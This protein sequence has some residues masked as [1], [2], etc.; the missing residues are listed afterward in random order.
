MRVEAVAGLLSDHYD[1]RSK[2]VRL[3]EGVLRE[4]SA[5]AVAVAAHECGHAIQH[6]QAYAPL[7]WRSA[8]VGPVNLLNTLAMPMFIA[9]A[10][11]QLFSLALV[12]VVLFGATTLFHLVTLPVEFDA[13]KRA[14][15]ILDG[16]GIATPEEMV[17]VRKVLNA[18][19]FTY[20]AATLVSAAQL[21]YWL[22]QSGLLGGRSQD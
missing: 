17:G 2:T 21:L 8:L 5:A 7:Q 20:L 22:L 12:A 18:A 15:G 11:F 10:V 16:S 19:G 6:A 9:G 14:I 1:P 13:S 4:R 3:S